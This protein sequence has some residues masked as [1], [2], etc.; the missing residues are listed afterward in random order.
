MSDTGGVL[1]MQADAG[2]LDMLVDVIIAIMPPPPGKMIRTHLI[3]V[4][5]LAMRERGILQFQR[6]REGGEA[7]NQIRSAI[8]AAIRRKLVAGD[9][10][11]VW[12][13]PAKEA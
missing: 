10:R 9:Q 6:L 13:L 5:A 2:S 4:A 3:G 8:N 1:E 11:Y 7:W 12:R